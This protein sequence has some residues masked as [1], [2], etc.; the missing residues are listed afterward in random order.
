VTRFFLARSQEIAAGK[1]WE[2]LENAESRAGFD[3][4]SFIVYPWIDAASLL[5][6]EE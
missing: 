4:R 3:L 5:I 1:I 2:T 6:G